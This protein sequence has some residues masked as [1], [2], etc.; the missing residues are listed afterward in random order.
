MFCPVVLAKTDIGLPPDGCSWVYHAT[1][2]ESCISIE[3]F[4]RSDIKNG[5]RKDF[6]LG[7]YVTPDMEY[8]KFWAK[9]WQKSYFSGKSAILVFSLAEDYIR[10][11]KQIRFSDL[12]EWRRFVKENRSGVDPIKIDADVVRGPVCKSVQSVNMCQKPNPLVYEQLCFK[13]QSATKLLKLKKIIFFKNAP[14]S[15]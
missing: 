7:F 9:T 3:N 14:P 13:S 6:G 12:D 5:K 4:I 8:A 2:W 15:R 11:I 1:D 10:L